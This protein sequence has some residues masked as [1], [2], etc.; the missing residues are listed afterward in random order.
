MTARRFLLLLLT[1]VA[2]TLAGCQTARY[3]PPGLPGSCSAGQQACYQHPIDGREILLKCNAGAVK[4]AIWLV[5]HVCAEG[6]LCKSSKC[7]PVS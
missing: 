3:P 5:D 2:A 4:G 1:L 7:V 6:E